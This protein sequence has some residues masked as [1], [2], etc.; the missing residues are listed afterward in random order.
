MSKGPPYFINGEL[1]DVPYG[2][3]YFAMAQIEHLN[4]DVSQDPNVVVDTLR[5]ESASEA[6]AT[7]LWIQNIL[8]RIHEEV[9]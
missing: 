9:C 3:K 6:Q 7:A 4:G 1:N 2:Q 5:P 8:Q